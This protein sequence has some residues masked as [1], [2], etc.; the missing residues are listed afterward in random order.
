MKEEKEEYYKKMEQKSKI[1]EQ[2]HKKQ[3]WKSMSKMV[4]INQ[5]ESTMEGC[6]S[7]TMVCK[8]DPEHPI[9]KG[10]RITRTCSQ[11]SQNMQSHLHK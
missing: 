11:I 2:Y 5:T 1:K 8:A 4:I 10:F 6:A 9:H 3:N 7:Y